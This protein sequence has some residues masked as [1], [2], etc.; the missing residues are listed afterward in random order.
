MKV[1]Y[2][3]DCESKRDRVMELTEYCICDGRDVDTETCREL[4]FKRGRLERM[5]SFASPEERRV[6]ME[7]IQKIPI[8]ES[9]NES[10]FSFAKHHDSVNI[11]LWRYY[12]YTAAKQC[13]K[14]SEERLRECMKR[15]ARA[16]HYA[17]NGPIARRIHGEGVLNRYHIK[18][19]ELH[20]DYEEELS[21][22][23]LENFDYKTPIEDGV[24]Q[25]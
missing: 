4:I 24:R 23:K 8:C 10:G 25:P 2:D 18:V 21:R 11:N 16:L 17:Q 5:L 7:E 15:L 14:N 22:V 20:D 12:V 19:E 13:L 3:P 6:I 1:F 9:K